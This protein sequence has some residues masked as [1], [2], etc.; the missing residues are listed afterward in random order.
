MNQKTKLIYEVKDLKKVYD[1]RAVLQIGRLQFHPGTVYGL[2]GPVGSG[3]STLLKILAGIEKQTDGTLTFEGEEF[4]SGWFGKVSGNENIFL[5][6]TEMLP[7]NKKISQVINEFFP[8]K[9]GNI[10]S[11]YFSKGVQKTFWDIA[12]KNLS[13]GEKAWVSMILA[14]EGDPRVLLIDDYGALLDSGLEYE[15]RR[16]LKKMNKDLGTTIILAAPT[17]QHIRKFAA[18]LIH[19]DNGHIAKIRPGAGKSS[20]GSYRN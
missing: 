20:S 12:V 7:D 14:V 9:A 10:Q 5:S 1:N 15:F 17:E 8:K 3:K 6:T 2:I 11:K 13:P 18:V 16:R 4:K 19:L